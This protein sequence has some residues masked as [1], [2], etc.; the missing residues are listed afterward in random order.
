[1]VYCGLCKSEKEPTY[2]WKLKEKNAQK[3]LENE[4]VICDDCAGIVLREMT[5]RAL[6]MRSNQELEEP[7]LLNRGGI[8]QEILLN[9]ENDLE[10]V[11]N[12]SFAK[13]RRWIKK[14]NRD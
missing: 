10:I 8:V 9:D 4:Y 5:K 3:E 7:V 1:M 14:A 2:Q 12:L 11:I 13:A 6:G